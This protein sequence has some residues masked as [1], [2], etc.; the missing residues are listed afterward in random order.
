MGRYAYSLSW[1]IGATLCFFVY[2]S[3]LFWL[4]QSCR[5]AFSKQ[6]RAV[7]LM[8]HRVATSADDKDISVHPRTFNR[9][10]S[11]LSKN[12]TVLS[13]HSLLDAIKQKQRFS[14][15]IV[16]ISFDDGFRDNYLNAFPILLHYKLPA[17]IFLISGLI[18]TRE[19]M[20]NWD[21]IKAMCKANISFGSHTVTHKILSTVDIE[22]ARHEIS[23]SKAEIENI[24]G[25]KIGLFAYPKGKTRHF[26]TQIKHL[27]EKAGYQAAFATENGEIH[28]HSDLFELKRIGIR[29][30]PLF[31]FKVRLS[32]IFETK[33][34]IAL[35]SILGLT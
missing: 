33:L 17:T 21:E 34:I 2:F 19:D 4:F 25:Q 32:G 14:R 16:A 9:Q 8:Y 27:V 28:F 7:V 24:L 30:F 11:Y 13:L 12:F 10:M 15:D 23:T 22:T 31:V 6:G 20:L 26:N 29:N 5:K 18:E 35:R 3:G 1:I